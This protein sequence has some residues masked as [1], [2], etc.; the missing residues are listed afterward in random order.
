MP[1]EHISVRGAR[2]HNLKNIDV[3]IPKNK[4]VVVTGLSGS[5]KSSLAFDT[6]YAEGQRRYMESLSNYARQF[7]EMQDK[8]EVDE[9]LGLSPTIAI[10]QRS[11]STNP[12]ST[13]GTVTEVYDFLRVLYAR[14]G[15]PHCPE[16]GEEVEEQTTT[17]IAMELEAMAQDGP[18]QVFAPVVEDQKG[19]HKQ[20]LKAAKEAEFDKVRFDGFLI[21]T[22]EAISMRKDKGKEHTI[23]VLVDELEELE[24]DEEY[25]D[26][27]M[28]KMVRKALD[29]GNG[30]LIAVDGNT[31]DEKL[32]SKSY[33]CTEC[34]V[35][36]PKPEPRL[37]SFNSPHGAC[38]ACTGLGVKLVFEPELVIPNKR[39]T[40]A[41]GA[42][43][44]WM[45]VAGNQKGYL[46]LVEAVGDEYGF[47]IDEPVKEIS[48]EN[49][50]I[51]LHGT[52]EEIYEI[53][54]EEKTFPGMIGLLDE[55]YN[56]TDSDYVRKKL[57]KYMRSMTCPACEGDRLRPEFLAVTILEHSIADLVNMS[58]EDLQDFFKQ[59]VDDT[60]SGTKDLTEEEKM[61]AERVSKEVLKRVTHLVKVGLG[62]L[63]L[64][65]SAV[66]LS[67]GESQRVRLASQLGS[68]LSG[69]VYILDEPSIGLHPRD[70]EQLIETIKGLRDL[71]NSV[72][73]VEHDEHMINAADYVFD[74]GPGAGENGGEIVAEGTPDDIRENEDSLT[75]KYLSGE[76]DIPVPAIEDEDEEEIEETTEEPE[77]IAEESAEEVS[78]EEQDAETQEEEQEEDK[79]IEIVGAK[80]FNLQDIDV[81]IPLGEMVCVTGVS[82][83][84]KSTL[85]LDILGKALSKHFHRAK[86]Y[87]G[88]HD[89]I[90]GLDNLNK[91][92][93]VD[94]SPIG[95]TPRSNPATYTGVFTPI[96]EL[97]T[98]VPE[99]QMRNFDAGKFSFNVKDGGRCEECS[100]EGMRKIEMQFLPD[101][102]VECPE[103]EGTRYNHEALEIH[104]K[105]KNIADVLAMTVEEARRFF[106]DQSTIYDKLNILYEVGLGY[107]QLGQPATTLSGGEAQRVK[108]STELSRRATGQTLYILDEPTTG[109]HFEDIK[110]LLGVL[111]RLVHKGNSVIVIE[112]N[113]DVVKSSDWVIDLGPEGGA[114]GGDIVVEGTPE[115]VAEHQTSITGEYLREI[116]D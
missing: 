16:C 67:G 44:P 80:A 24:D 54:G 90:K 22:T 69:V 1:Q 109:L 51:L 81:E 113:L 103:C 20:V 12:R 10:D 46:D 77:E 40:I 93:T 61:V 73:V 82:G 111:R 99:A 86:A 39:L 32:F 49:Q 59:F 47:T 17:Q 14:A 48:E 98:E 105:Q 28:V 3:D 56:E 71:D 21:E 2:V 30:L 33:T 37:F 96:R 13:V 35:D 45:R 74:I 23:D 31:G 68:S 36:L 58:L 79:S 66:T 85:V 110:R 76:K 97:F 5:G 50:E 106:A 42:V 75:G 104:Y 94:Q 18:V 114:K 34:G 72:I 87:P 101:V 41:E 55:K 108:L 9:I 25:E 102:Y 43:Q 65:R 27:S 83:S 64:D 63:T 57:E 92:V 100:G 8:P 91:V 53:D 15:R 115:E 78:G 26:E 112:H 95:R 116:M 88:E 11:S 38:E 29:Y 107:L 19:A 62:Y 7:M 4:L 70:N 52:G 84:G 89:E 6:V 60:Q